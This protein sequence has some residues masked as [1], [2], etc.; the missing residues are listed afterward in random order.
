MNLHGI[1]YENAREYFGKFAGYCMLCAKENQMIGIEIVPFSFEGKNY[2]IRI[3]SDG[4]TI[5]IRAFLN[6]KPANG[7][8]LRNKYY[9]LT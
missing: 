8:V 7:Y 4:A 2:E 9:N 1:P 5:R 3:A 6:G